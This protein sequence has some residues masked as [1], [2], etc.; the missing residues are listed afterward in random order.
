[1]IIHI[2]LTAVTEVVSFLVFLWLLNLILYQPL[3]AIFRQRSERVDAG[4]RAAEES[5]RRADETRQEVERR[6]NA[7][8]VEAQSIIAAATRDAATQRQSLLEQARA[9]GESLVQQAQE[10]IRQERA[11]AVEALR[12][13]A[14]PLAILAAS[15][16]VGS[17]LD[18][19]A[20]R[21]VADRAIA[22]AGEMR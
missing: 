13:E 2:D 15:R 5:N 4:L 18:S 9:Q 16:V 19:E 1:V 8:R 17:S 14:V 12:R 6:L 7:A 21:A 11:V 22:E 20:N 3:M 10:E